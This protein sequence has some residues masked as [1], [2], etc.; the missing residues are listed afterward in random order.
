MYCYNVIFGGLF[1]FGFKLWFWVGN[2][3]DVFKYDGIYK[4][5]LEYFYKYGWVYKICIGRVLVIV[6]CDFE[7]VK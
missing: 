3:Y 4:M 2:F 6:V 7:I 5:L 1:L